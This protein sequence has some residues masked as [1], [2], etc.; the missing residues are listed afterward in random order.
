[1]YLPISAHA[2]RP[3]FASGRSWS[4]TPAGRSDLA[5]LSSISRRMAL[6]RTLAPKVRRQY[7][8]MSP[9]RRGC[10]DRLPKCRPRGPRLLRRDR[11]AGLCHAPMPGYRGR[12]S[13]IRSAALRRSWATAAS[14]RRDRRVRRCDDRIELSQAFLAI[15]VV[16]WWWRAGPMRIHS[17][18]IIA[19]TRDAARAL[20]ALPA[21]GE[22]RGEIS[23]G[24]PSPQYCP[25]SGP[26]LPRTWTLM[27]SCA[28]HS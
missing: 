19:T 14:D 13:T 25:G 22:A 10:P 16:R 6:S 2:S 9:F 15:V 20:T 23:C 27:L 8:I 11:E 28:A 26:R 5:C 4:G 21:A 3:E 24:P 7:A 12:C 1:M 18:S 17:F